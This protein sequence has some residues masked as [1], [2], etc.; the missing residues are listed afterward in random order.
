MISYYY[1]MWKNLYCFNSKKNTLYI[2]SIWLIKF[3]MSYLD[4]VLV[5]FAF[6]FRI[7]KI[8]KT[9]ESL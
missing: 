5:L 1:E 6:S 8:S 4:A 3:L 7:C 2:F 9:Y